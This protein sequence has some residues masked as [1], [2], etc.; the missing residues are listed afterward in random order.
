MTFAEY[1]ISRPEFAG[2]RR[3]LE[4]LIHLTQLLV[5]CATSPPEPE[6]YQLRLF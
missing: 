4:A 2:V 1:I 3:F 6:P 5:Q